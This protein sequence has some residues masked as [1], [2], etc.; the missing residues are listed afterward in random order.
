MTSASNVRLRSAPATDAAV[1]A[2]LP[3]GTELAT[4]GPDRMAEWIPVRTVLDQEQ[5]GWVAGSLTLPVSISTYQ[6]VVTGLIAERLARDGDGF[7]ARA[8]LLDLTESALRRD[9]SPDDAALLELQRLRALRGVLQTIP[10]ARSRWQEPMREWVASRS[11]EIRY[12]EPGGSWMLRHEL[13]LALHDEHRSSRAADEIAWLYVTNGLPGECE[14]GL[15]CNLEATD[16]LQGEYLR[17]EPGGRHV[18]E[19]AARVQWVAEYEFSAGQ[20]RFY[21]D[22]Q[23]EC[24]AL[25]G[26]ISSLET[27]LRNSRVSRRTELVAQLREKLMLCR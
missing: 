17:R 18:E 3:L 12:H 1:V 23:R 21:F 20:S 5:Q 6:D 11:D 9:R 22:P 19:A 16:K 7:V 24:D 27:A 2:M 26:V 10:F 14:G 13:I 25:A 15:V 8:E 4:T